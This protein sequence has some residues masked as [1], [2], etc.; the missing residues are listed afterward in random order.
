MPRAVARAAAY[1]TI[2]IAMS[3]AADPR[4]ESAKQLFLDG[5][6]AFSAGRFAVAEHAFLAS[7]ERL[8]QRVSTLVNLA[9]TRLKLGKSEAA[10]DVADLV[11]ALEADNAEALFHRASAL[12]RLGRHAEALAAYD[13]LLALAPTLGTAWSQRG[14]VLREMGR[15]AEAAHSFERAIEHGADAELNRYYL[16]AVGADRGP[17]TAPRPYV[18]AL[19]DTY[20]GQFDEHLVK[21]LHYRAPELLVQQLRSLARG[22]WRSALDLGC[23]TGLLGPLVKPLVARLVGVDLSQAMLD[24]AAALG[25]YDRLVC[26]DIVEHL[27]TETEPHDLVLATDVFIYVGDLAPVFG[28]LQRVLAPGGLF[29]FSAERAAAGT[30][31]FEL[32][33]SL[34]YAHAEPYLRRLAAEHGL[35]VTALQHGPL[36]V[37]QQGTI[38]GL[39]VCCERGPAR[40]GA[41]PN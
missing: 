2:G 39:Y 7:L 12:D 15:L 25:V 18:Q 14:G 23:G 28:A 13:A 27:Q 31:E 21:V 26:A 22:P 8:P 41:A 20:A 32:Q 35:V 38:E 34:R 6:A 36:R 17:G 11:L 30:P 37:D 16:A 1:A 40:G 5:L 9:A 33:A 24:K 4:F 29:C 19:F 3:D 10:L